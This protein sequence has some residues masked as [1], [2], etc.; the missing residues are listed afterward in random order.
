[1]LDVGGLNVEVMKAS[2]SKRITVHG[3]YGSEHS[4]HITS[5]YMFFISNPQLAYV[6]LWV[7]VHKW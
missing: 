3:P 7:A 4:H 6:Y 2:D 1:M 5:K